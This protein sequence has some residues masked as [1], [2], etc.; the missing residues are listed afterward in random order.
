MFKTAL[1][2]AIM[3][4][5]DVEASRLKT[6]STTKAQTYSSEY[7]QE[8][9]TTTGSYD[10]SMPEAYS[11]MG[12]YYSSKDGGSGYYYYSVEPGT[13]SRYSSKYYSPSYGMSG[14]W[15]ESEDFADAKGGRQGSG[16]YHYYSSPP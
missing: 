13:K 2:A 9:K 1:I 10:K 8:S 12:S 7:N 5:A 3:L 16:T 11:Y 15:G 6:R 4:T 14:S